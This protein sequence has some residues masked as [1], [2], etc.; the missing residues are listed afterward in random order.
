VLFAQSLLQLA[1]NI[2]F[3]HSFGTAQSIPSAPKAIR[4]EH[5]FR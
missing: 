2:A 5:L 3:W 1:K 4:R